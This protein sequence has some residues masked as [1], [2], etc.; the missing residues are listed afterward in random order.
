MDR[1]VPIFSFYYDGFSLETTF[2]HINFETLKAKGFMQIVRGQKE[3][4]SLMEFIY[5]EYCSW[6]KN[7]VEPRNTIMH[8]N[9]LQSKYR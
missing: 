3:Q 8:Y 1:T 9:D 4:D 7:I 6:I 5:N 2:G